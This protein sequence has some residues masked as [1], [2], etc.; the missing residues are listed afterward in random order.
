MLPQVLAAFAAGDI[1]YRRA[2]LFYDL[3]ATV[4]DTLAAAIAAT[5]LPDAG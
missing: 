2:W 4:D 3:L 5:L 1:D